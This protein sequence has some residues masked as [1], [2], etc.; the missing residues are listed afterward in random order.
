MVISALYQHNIIML[1]FLTESTF[2]LTLH[3]YTSCFV[4]QFTFLITSE[5]I[6]LF[7]KVNNKK[8]LLMGYLVALPPPL[9]RLTRKSLR[10]EIRLPYPTPPKRSP[11]GVPSEPLRHFFSGRPTKSRRKAE[12]EPKGL[13]RGTVCRRLVDRRPAKQKLPA[14]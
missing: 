7:T 9:H 6:V 2:V 10:R 13:H 1:L 11:F 3:L 12:G 4:S 5:A 8:S 14:Y